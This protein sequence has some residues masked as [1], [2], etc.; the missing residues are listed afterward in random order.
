MEM[1]TWH[2]THWLLW[3]RFEMADRYLAKTY[4]RFLGGSIDRAQKQ[5]VR[6]ET[7]TFE[8]WEHETDQVCRILRDIAKVQG[9]PR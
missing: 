5:Q 9:G 2:A 4:R 7:G 8:D 6:N 3:N 1:V